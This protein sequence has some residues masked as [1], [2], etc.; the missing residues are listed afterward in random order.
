MVSFKIFE[1]GNDIHSHL[2]SDMNEFFE[3]KNVNILHMNTVIETLNSI[4]YK[5]VILC[6]EEVDEVQDE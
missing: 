4:C 2:Q 6:Y 1:E 3:N 5:S